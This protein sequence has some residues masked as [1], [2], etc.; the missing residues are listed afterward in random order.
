M[1]KVLCE[2][3]D[4]VAI[5]DA[6]RGKTG[7]TAE[8]SLAAMPGKINGINGGE[9]IYEG[10][11]TVTFPNNNLGASFYF[12]TPNGNFGSKIYP[13]SNSSF[14]IQVLKNTI[15]MSDVFCFGENT[16]II[17]GQP[18]TLVKSLNEDGYGIVVHGD[19]VLRYADNAPA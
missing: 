15:L 9:I 19:V 1:S 6:I 2:R 7:E 11:C 10:S 4:L 5:A 16:Y 18:C 8:M 3:E 12:I 13:P 17:E 14:T